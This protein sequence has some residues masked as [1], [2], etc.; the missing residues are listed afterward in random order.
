MMVKNNDWVLL[1]VFPNVASFDKLG[2]FVSKE[3]YEHRKS[4]ERKFVYNVTIDDY[5][6]KSKYFEKVAEAKKYYATLKAKYKR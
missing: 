4:G 2:L 6:L 3:L 1:N 5:P